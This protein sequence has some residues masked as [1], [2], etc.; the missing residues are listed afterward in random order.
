MNIRI[1]VGNGILVVLYI[2]VFMFIQLFGFMN[3]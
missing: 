1:L 2:V 3:V